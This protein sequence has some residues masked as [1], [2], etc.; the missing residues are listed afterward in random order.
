MRA[1]PFLLA[2]L[3]VSCGA[4]RK[5]APPPVAPKPV[6]KT[7][8]ER[9]YKVLYVEGAFRPDY[10]ALRGV[11]YESES[12][13]YQ[14]LLIVPKDLKRGGLPTELHATP[15]PGLKALAGFPDT[16]R[17][18]E[19]Y[20]VVVLGDIDPVAVGGHRGI[21]RLTRY[22][23]QGGGLILLAGKNHTPKTYLSTDLRRLLPF[24]QALQYEE[25]RALMILSKT[26]KE[27]PVTRLSKD[28]KLNDEIW[29]KVG[30][31]V[32]FVTVRGLRNADPILLE[33][34]Y[35]LSPRS[36]ELVREP[37]LVCHRVGKGRVLAILTDTLHQ[38]KH[39]VTG[40]Q[41]QA[42]L[43]AQALEWARRRK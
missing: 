31:H 43:Y 42:R 21:E 25:K 3:V 33:A 20:D 37:V 14:V 39:V 18:L 6:G 34:E 4:P 36:K 5:A 9:P 30:G 19:E 17:K 16:S 22:V 8:A 28:P 12:F 1:L 35:V 15:G 26:G 24:D 23:E 40:R 27:H 13:N 10:R 32:G 7:K 41:V 29:K 11:L 38:I 2:L